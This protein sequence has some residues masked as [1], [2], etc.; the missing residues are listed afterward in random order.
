MSEKLR[1]RFTD[2]AESWIG[3]ELTVGE[4]RFVMDSAFWLYS[5]LWELTEALLVAIRGDD[6]TGIARWLVGSPEY[7]FVFHNHAEQ[8][9]L[10]V[11]FYPDHGR[12]IHKG[13]VVFSY[14]NT[15]LEVVL[16]FW[17]AL[18]ALDSQ[19]LPERLRQAMPEKELNLLTTRLK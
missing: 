15:R 10:E 11:I 5:S 19:K 14:R 18:R 12:S 7:D 17:R 3:L 16:P 8:T 6:S 9:H 2:I 13:D 4:E 1:V